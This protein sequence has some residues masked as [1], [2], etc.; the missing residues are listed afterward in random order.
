MF[1]DEHHYED[2]WRGTVRRIYD[3]LAWLM[4]GGLL[5]LVVLFGLAALAHGAE[6]VDL[7]PAER[8]EVTRGGSLKPTAPAELL[9]FH[10]SWCAPCRQMEPIVQR[11]IADGYPIRSIDVDREPQL[12]AQFAISSIPAFVA[13]R[14]GQAIARQVGGTSYE[15]LA[16]MIT[17]APASKSGSATSGAM[18]QGWYVT[19]NFAVR[20]P[21][22]QLAAAIGDTAEACRSKHAQDWLGAELPN[23][24]QRCPITARVG[25]M[26][27]GGVTSFA[28]NG[29]QAGDWR[30]TVQGT[31]QRVL[32][33][34]VPHEVLHTVFATHFG[35][36]LPRWADEGAC[37]TVESTPEQQRHQQ[38]LITFLQSGR[39][40]EFGRLL[41]MKEYPPDM[42]PLYAQGHSL[43]RMLIAQ[44]GRREFV[45]FLSDG[46]QDEDWTRAVAAHYGDNSLQALQSRWLVWV[47]SGSSGTAE[48]GKPTPAE[49]IASASPSEQTP[50]VRIRVRDRDGTN[51]LGSGVVIAGG[52]SGEQSIVLTAYHV[53]RDRASDAL[54]IET[55]DGRQYPGRFVGGG[56]NPDLAVLESTQLISGIAELTEDEVA[57]GDDVAIAGYGGGQLGWQQGRVSNTQLSHM[58]TRELVYFEIAGAIARSGDSGGPV[59]RRHECCGVLW[60]ASNATS[61]VKVGPIRRLL[62]KL[63]PGRKF[64]R[65]D[66][67][68]PR[69]QQQRAQPAVAPQQPQQFAPA[70]PAPVAPAP[71]VQTPAASCH[72]DNTPV[73]N[74]LDELLALEKQTAKG[75][76]ALTQQLMAAGQSLSQQQAATQQEQTAAAAERKGML[77]KLDDLKQKLHDKLSNVATRED[78]GAVVHQQETSKETIVA[79]IAGKA[80]SIGWSAGSMIAAALGLSTPLGFGAGVVGWLVGRRIKKKIG[81]RKSEVGA[82]E[83]QTSDFRPP[84]VQQR[85]VILETPPPPQVIERSQQFVPYQAENARLE[86]LERAMAE[87]VRK[88]PSAAGVFETVNNYA[89][90]FQSGDSKPPQ[91]K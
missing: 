20:A 57:L 52:A 4:F 51:S 5:A 78:V 1:S 29:G 77:G 6:L 89:N 37:T 39:G 48:P 69:P 83:T 60:G 72:C 55:S 16:A 91:K 63:F 32:D 53:V 85:T 9:F 87:Y 54:I 36:P 61:G 80:P 14:D 40:I 43:A 44:R 73:L 71:I 7:T 18:V 30:M 86:A 50:V 59:L 25:D 2:S 22:E 88:Y 42:L 23:W 41:T 65:C 10:A 19:P 13:V 21:S 24:R 68:P 27:A 31:A 84:T 11:L 82:S 33:S 17:P 56:E 3:G 75:Q 62:G 28:F 46:L 58:G 64:G 12:K 15:H 79:A 26:G 66:R 34:V 76:S 70:A 35:E 45:A 67:R 49:Q 81:K 8:I 47:Q 38:M 74:R 90:Q